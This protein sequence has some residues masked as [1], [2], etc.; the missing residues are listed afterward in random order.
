[1]KAVALLV[2]AI[3]C[4]PKKPVAASSPSSEPDCELAGPGK[5]ACAREVAA[6][7]PA[8]AATKLMRGY[9]T[10]GVAMFEGLDQAPVSAQSWY[11]IGRAAVA[12]APRVAE[13]L[14]ALAEKQR[15]KNDDDLAVAIAI[16]KVQVAPDPLA[17]K[18][19]AVPVLALAPKTPRLLEQAI[20]TVSSSEIVAQLCHNPTPNVVWSCVER[21]SAGIAEYLPAIARLPSLP[22]RELAVL[23]SSEVRAALPGLQCLDAPPGPDAAHLDRFRP[24]GE[25]RTTAPSEIVIYARIRD[26]L[27]PA[28]QRCLLEEASVLC[29]GMINKQTECPLPM[30]I[31]DYV[32]VLSPQDQ[33]AMIK[34]L[35]DARGAD[36]QWFYGGGDKAGEVLLHLHLV[37]ADVLAHRAASVVWETTPYHIARAAALWKRLGDPRVQFRDVLPWDAKEACRAGAYY[38]TH[39]CENGA[40]PR[41]TSVSAC[42]NSCMTEMSNPDVRAACE[43]KGEHC[44]LL[45]GDT[46]VDRKY[47]S[48]WLDLDELTTLHAGASLQLK[49]G[50][51]AKYVLVRLLPNGKSRDQKVGILGRYPVPTGRLLVIPL[52]NDQS[53]I[54]QISVH[55]AP[56]AWDLSLSPGNGPA[57]LE[58]VEICN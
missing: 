14:F 13:G 49:I 7:D 28:E 12:H 10:F 19:A 46:N 31:A 44:E 39:V 54:A 26:G 37:F 16:G 41:S 51:S 18:A 34:K 8:T 9:A 45:L 48:G 11:A 56:K 23:N 33:A 40:R 27:T 57:T 43:A 5:L 30:V 3:A 25:Y 32:R 35:F 1:M 15:D 17:A 38:C 36:Y 22:L 47:G 58:Q 4:A 53:D 29:L 42:Q 24:D 52:K 50:G 2:I 21:N 20:A 55:G 6:I